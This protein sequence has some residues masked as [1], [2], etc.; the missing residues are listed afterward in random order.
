MW[1]EYWFFALQDACK[2]FLSVNFGLFTFHVC[3]KSKNKTIF[4]VLLDSLYSSWLN[5]FELFFWLESLQPRTT[6]TQWRHKSN[7]S[8]KLGR[9]GRQNMLRPYLNI[10]DGIKFLAVQWRI[11]SLWVS[12]VR[13]LNQATENRA[14]FYHIILHE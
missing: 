8:E 5:N 12:I 4:K 7:I 6:D 1:T 14:K 2:S 11:S 9:C 13:D 10:W 3:I